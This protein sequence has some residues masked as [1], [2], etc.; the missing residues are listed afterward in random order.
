[1]KHTWYNQYAHIFRTDGRVVRA[2]LKELVIEGDAIYIKTEFIDHTG[3]IK[4]KDTSPITIAAL[5]VL[6]INVDVVSD[7]EL[8][9]DFDSV[10][11]FTPPRECDR[12]P[13]LDVFIDKT[14]GMN[15]LLLQVN[16]FVG[17]STPVAPPPSPKRPRIRRS[18]RHRTK[19]DTSSGSVGP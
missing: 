19:K 16:H 12:L 17:L 7:V 4:T 2:T 6:W 3:A 8:P 11:D 15:C 9:D 5:Q 10:T 14:P 13:P 18:T 1:M